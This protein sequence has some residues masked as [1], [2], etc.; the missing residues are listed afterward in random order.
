[1]RPHGSTLCGMSIRVLVAD[2]EFLIREAVASIVGSEADFELVAVVSTGEELRRQAVK[3]AP[4]VVVTDIRMPPTGTNEGIRIAAE[5]RSDRPGV[6]V[7]VL[8][9]HADPEY[10]LALFDQGSAGRAY[11][12]KERI[13]HAGE[14]AHA[15]RAVSAGGSVV[16][17]KVVERL[18]AAR[19][20]R[21]SSLDLLTSRERE[22]LAEMASGRNNAAIA[23]RLVLTERAVLKHINSIF[24]KLDLSEEGE[25]HKRVRAVLLYLADQEVEFR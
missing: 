4:D 24:S 12:L 11:L 19:S 1:M 9:Q 22:V 25:I 10:A 15:I 3:V 18:V 14:L 16:D 20:R 2:D 21:P 23:T 6:G 13:G 17:P 5:L 7:V 8:S